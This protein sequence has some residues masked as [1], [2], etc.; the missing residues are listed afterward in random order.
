MHA[1]I[2]TA[3]LLGAAGLAVADLMLA[4]MTRAAGVSA[5]AAAALVVLRN[6][7]GLGVTELGRRI[8]LSQS[9]ATRM[10]DSLRASGLVRR[11]VKPGRQV[12]LSL[13]EAGGRAVRQLIRARAEPL[14]ELVGTLD[15]AQRAALDEL[16]D[17][18][19]AHLYR[20]VGETEL[21]CR[22][23]D[24]AS[25]VQGSHCPVGAAARS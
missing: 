25:C 20:Q 1:T 19:L 21:L 13:T 16:L 18:L 12:S 22:V 14:N 3:N 6:S 8:G 23:C 15:P 9:A 4:A 10:V 17:V 2:R 11:Q 5:S 24:R 7:P